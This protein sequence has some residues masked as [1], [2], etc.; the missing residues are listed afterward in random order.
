MKKQKTKNP[1]MAKMLR[2][3]GHQSKDIVKKGSQSTTECAKA[4]GETGT[5]GGRE[6]QHLARVANKAVNKVGSSR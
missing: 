6:Q 5:A 1:H 2:R 4:L 3:V